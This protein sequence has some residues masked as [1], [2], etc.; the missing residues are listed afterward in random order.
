[1]IRGGEVEEN[2]GKAFDLL[3]G[4]ELS[5]VVD[6][7]GAEQVRLLGDDLQEPTVHGSSVAGGKFGQQ[8]TSLTLWGTIAGGVTGPNSDGGGPDDGLV[9]LRPRCLTAIRAVIYLIK[10]FVCLIIG[11]LWIEAPAK[12]CPVMAAEDVIVTNAPKN[13]E[14]DFASLYGIKFRLRH[15]RRFAIRAPQDYRKLPR[16]IWAQDGM[17]ESKAWRDRHANI[18]EFELVGAGPR[19]RSADVGDRGGGSLTDVTEVDRDMQFLLW[20]RRPGDLAYYNPRSLIKVQRLTCGGNTLFAVFGAYL[21]GC[22]GICAG[23]ADAVS[24]RVRLLF[25][26]GKLLV[27]SRL[28]FFGARARIGQLLAHNMKLREHHVRL[29][30]HDVVL[31]IG[32]L[33]LKVACGATSYGNDWTQDGQHDRQSRPLL[34]AFNLLVLFSISVGLSAAAYLIVHRWGA[35]LLSVTAALLLY[36]AVFVVLLHAI[37]CAGKLYEVFLG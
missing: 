7:D 29:L 33:P 4:V 14:R 22:G 2:A 35:R 23:W 26:S 25:K 9:P 27:E 18:R 24:H 11:C 13:I 32:S 28:F 5:A 15:K 3:V 10:V 37:R 36:L 21:S 34:Q 20:M 12:A 19:M 30:R 6:G 17:A 1:V 16:L 31:E 8:Y